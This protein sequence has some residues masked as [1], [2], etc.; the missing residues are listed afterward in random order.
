MNA[1]RRWLGHP[2]LALLF[3]VFFIVSQSLIVYT[4]QAGNAEA[5]LIKLQLTFSAAE[6]NQLLTQATPEQ[7][8]AL[9]QHYLF[10]YVHPIWYGLL[11][12][13]LTSVLFNLNGFSQRSNIWLWPAVIFPS[14]DVLE[15]ALHSPWIYQYAQATDPM[16]LIAGTA[17]SIKWS[18]AACYILAALIL[19][20]RYLMRRQTLRPV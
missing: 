11:A 8:L 3:A 4:L 10:D 5:L 7:I 16:V 9:Q 6:F 14:L 19:W 20:A 15:N 18:L 13:S 2:R 17:A 12:L 1:I